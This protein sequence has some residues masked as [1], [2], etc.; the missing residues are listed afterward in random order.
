MSWSQNFVFDFRTFPVKVNFVFLTRD[1]AVVKNIVD[2]YW[3]LLGH[4]YSTKNVIQFNRFIFVLSISHL[5]RV[6]GLNL[7]CA[8]SQ[9][10][11]FTH[12]SLK[13]LFIQVAPMC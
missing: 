3:V 2:D 11:D 8:K 9:N 13:E 4:G 1:V 6:L 10:C 12:P 7:F 5:K